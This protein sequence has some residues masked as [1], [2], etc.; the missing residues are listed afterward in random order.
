MVAFG[1]PTDGSF[2]GASVA[3]ACVVRG[4]ST[5]D[6]MGFAEGS[7]AGTSVPFSD[8]VTTGASVD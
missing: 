1:T 8:D 2:V 5:G 3:G 6:D 4:V 7:V